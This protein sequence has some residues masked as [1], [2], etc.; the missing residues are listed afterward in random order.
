[1]TLAKKA[2]TRPLTVRLMLRPGQNPSALEAAVRALE[3]A[4]GAGRIGPVGVHGLSA[5]LVFDGR[6][7]SPEQRRQIEEVLEVAGRI[8]VTEVAVD[9]ELRSALVLR[10]ESRLRAS[11]Q[12]PRDSCRRRSR[13]ASTRSGVRSLCPPA[14]PR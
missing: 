10:F 11:Q 5:L 3:T 9:G 1:M 2:T 14:K 13:S 12:S 4:R 8:G 7:E 6:I